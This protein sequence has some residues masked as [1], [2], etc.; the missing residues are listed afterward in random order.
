MIV[1]AEP[2]DQAR[3]APYGF[4][5]PRPASAGR[6]SLDGMLACAR[7]EGR[8]GASITR[9]DPLAA[10]DSIERMER[11]AHTAQL[12]LPLEG[13][14][15]LILTALG[16]DAPDMATLAAWIVPADIGIAYGKGVWH[17]PMRVLDA[18]AAF[19]V[20]MQRISPSLDEDWHTLGDP[21]TIR[22]Q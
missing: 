13:S 8:L 19:L 16:G 17:A 15:Y 7:P 3:F 14:R 10:P 21:V 1:A 6:T 22:F 11:H 2:F 18:P 5:V 12:F 4:A 20:L 9:L